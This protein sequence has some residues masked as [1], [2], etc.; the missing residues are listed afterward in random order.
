[1][2]ILKTNF[3]E[4]VCSFCHLT[5]PKKGGEIKGRKFK[6]ADCIETLKGKK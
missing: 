2:M 5:K 6:C 3:A 4:R 1:M